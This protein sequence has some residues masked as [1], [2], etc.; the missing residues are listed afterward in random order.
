MVAEFKHGPLDGKR[1]FFPLGKSS[2]T[3]LVIHNDRDHLYRKTPRITIDKKAQI[4]QF[5][6]EVKETIF[7]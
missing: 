1:R 7:N 2:D 6:G 4:Y 5:I 3:I